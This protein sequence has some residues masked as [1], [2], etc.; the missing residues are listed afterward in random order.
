MKWLLVFVALPGVGWAQFGN[1]DE[2]V[3]HLMTSGVIT[4]FEMKAL[5]RTGDSAAAAVTRL[6]APMNLDVAAM[7]RAL[8]IVHT[9]FESP[10]WMDHIADREPT[11]TLSLLA[12]LDG[13]T[14]DDAVR[15]KIVD[16][17]LFVL[18]QVA[19]LKVGTT[20]L[21][22]NHAAASTVR[23][24][25]VYRLLTEPER[26]NASKWPRIGDGV[27]GILT[28]LMGACTL[29]EDSTRRIL[30]VVRWSFEAP[31][32]NAEQT[33]ALLENLKATG[34]AADVAAARQFVSAQTA[35]V[36]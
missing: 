7:N 33:L 30:N 15:K 32:A 27:A 4:G 5:S 31:Q 2:S 22:A 34:D 9:S 16:E 23:A 17:R 20:C 36:Q 14:H 18:D 25:R 11:A 10:A 26:I 29:D 8:M 21:I 19:K 6:I 1:V 24:I 12:Y 28:N 3:T 13:Q 35:K